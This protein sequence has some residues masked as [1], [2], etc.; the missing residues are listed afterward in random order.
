MSSKIFKAVPE[1]EGLLAAEYSGLAASMARRGGGAD[2]VWRSFLAV[3]LNRAASLRLEAARALLDEPEYAEL[4]ARHRIESAAGGGGRSA[5]LRIIERRTLPVLR[6]SRL[7]RSAIAASIKPGEALFSFKLGPERS[8]R[9]VLAGGR[10]SLA[11]LPSRGELSRRIENLRTAVASDSP[12]LQAQSASLYANLF[13]GTPAAAL[14]ASRWLLS[15]DEELFALPFSALGV[16]TAG[17]F[18]WLPEER[19]LAVIPAAALLQRPRRPRPPGRLAAFGDPIYNPAD[20]RLASGAGARG[21]HLVNASFVAPRLAGSGA[22]VRRAAA[23]WRG[24][25]APAEVYLGG[26]VTPEAVRAAV[27][28]GAGIV[29]IASHVLDESGPSERYAL[30]GAAWD[31]AALRSG[32]EVSLRLTLDREGRPTALRPAAIR[33]LHV[34]AS[35]IVLSGCSSGRGVVQSAAG[36]L[37]LSRAWLAAGA[38]AMI[39]SLWPVSDGRGEFF[40]RFYGRLGAGATPSRA[41]REAQVSMIRSGSWRSQPRH[42][43]AWFLTTSE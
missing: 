4:L 33:R 15:L 28:R 21:P 31:G 7:S 37:G 24:L 42:W 11:E 5:A 22:E 26:E 43:A 14:R 36:L 25:G 29:H 40:E 38:R 8:W 32:G 18:R 20:P 23:V 30:A 27:E 19:E 3:E 2:L 9:W 17:R 10:L 16:E 35:L 39:G 34:P 41:L 6:D 12:G 1:T 13:G